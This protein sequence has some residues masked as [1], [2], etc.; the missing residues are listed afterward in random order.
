[1]RRH[2]PPQCMSAINAMAKAAKSG[3][4]PRDR[5]AAP[6]AQ[7]P[8]PCRAYLNT[9]AVPARGIH[10]HGPACQAGRWPRRGKCR[11]YRSKRPVGVFHHCQQGAQRA[12]QQGM[13]PWGLESWQRAQH[14]ER[15][16]AVMR[17]TKK[18]NAWQVLS[19]WCDPPPSP[20]CPCRS[21]VSRIYLAIVAVVKMHTMHSP[22]CQLPGIA[23]AHFEKYSHTPCST[24]FWTAP[25]IQCPWCS[26]P[27]PS[28]SGL[29]ACLQVDHH[30][31]LAVV[32]DEAEYRC[33]EHPAT[34]DEGL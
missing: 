19:A 26:T 12:H 10:V 11:S 4:R 30:L 2:G 25:H 8:V 18:R 28:P 15:S 9:P 20:V 23:R 29:L 1:M 6:G 31:R 3:A 17:P 14:G 21:A 33:L 32:C 22:F 34:A 24:P 7:R 27:S 13:G 5:A 16:G